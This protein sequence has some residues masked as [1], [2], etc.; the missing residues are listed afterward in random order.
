[1]VSDEGKAPGR[2]CKKCSRY[3]LIESPN[4]SGPVY[5]LPL[6]SLHSLV[7]FSLKSTVW[8]ECPDLPGFVGLLGGG[9]VRSLSNLFAMRQIPDGMCFLE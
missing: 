9:K 2:G 7:S 3:C 8:C 5:P 1:M 4:S 6:L